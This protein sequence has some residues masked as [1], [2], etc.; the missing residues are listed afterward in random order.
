MDQNEG[1][2]AFRNVAKQTK[3]SAA[4]CVRS[5]KLVRREPTGCLSRT[6][7]KKELERKPSGP[8]NRRNPL[9]TAWI[10]ED[11]L[12]SLASIKVIQ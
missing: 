8:R 1:A 10:W 4:L 5:R 2:T 12:V 9:I 6:A 11:V 3:E 7:K